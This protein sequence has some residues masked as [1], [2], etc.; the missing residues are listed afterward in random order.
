[1]RQSKGSDPT[2]AEIAEA[3]GLTPERVREIRDSMQQLVSL[4]K[5]IGEDGDATMGD[6]IPDLAVVDPAASALEGE[7][8]SQIEAALAELEP[9]Q[10]RVLE[11]RYGLAGG[12]RM[13]YEHIG[14]QLGLTRERIRQLHNH[15]LL[16]LR[17][18][19]HADA[20]A[21]LLTEPGQAA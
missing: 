16:D 3:V 13:T 18:S 10:R 17:H 20:L 7:A 12:E 21:E 15:A 4:D 5:P 1:L 19:P 14:E 9:R 8:L 2:E 6:L 11:L